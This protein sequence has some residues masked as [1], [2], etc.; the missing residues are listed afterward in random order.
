MK[1][2]PFNYRTIQGKP[3]KLNVCSEEIEEIELNYTKKLIK[4]FCDT[5]VNPH[6]E[7]VISDDGENIIRLQLFADARLS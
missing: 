7:V 3:I 4:K 6:V 1:N 2:A 5:L